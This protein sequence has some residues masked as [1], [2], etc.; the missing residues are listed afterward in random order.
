MSNRTP[1]FWDIAKDKYQDSQERQKNL[2]VTLKRMVSN[3]R[4]VCNTSEY[5]K[6]T[7]PMGYLFEHIK[8]SLTNLIALFT[9]PDT[10]KELEKH[11][12]FDLEWNKTLFNSII[13]LDV[14]DVLYWYFLKV[15]YYHRH[16]L[17]KR[18]EI[19]MDMFD[20]MLENWTVE[21]GFNEKSF[22]FMT[23]TSY[24]LY[25]SAYH[26]RSNKELLSKACKLI[27]KIC[28]PVN[29]TNPKIS[30]IKWKPQD[31]LRIC[32]IS[33]SLTQDTSVLRDRMGIILNLPVAQFDVYYATITNMENNKNAKP[34]SKAFYNKM[35]KFEKENGKNKYIHLNENLTSARRTL[36]NYDFH[37]IIYPDLGMKVFQTFL[38]YSRIAPIQINTW[39]HSDTSGIDTIDYYITSKF[40]EVQDENE[41]RSHYSEEPILLPSFGT[42][43]YSPV[44]MFIKDKFVLQTRK[45]LGFEEDDHIYWCMQTFYKFSEELED[46][47][48]QIIKSDPK[49]HLLLSH[50]I[51]FCHSHLIRMKNKFGEESMKRIHTYP[52]EGKPKF[53]SMISISDVVLDPYPFGGCNSSI[54]AFDLGIPVVSMP[55]KFING[56]FTYGFY[57][58]MGIHECLVDNADDYVKIALKLA[59]NPEYR[60]M[61]VKKINRQKHLLFQD[62]ESVRDWSSCLMKLADKHFL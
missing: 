36:E 59:N 46:M 33:D 30:E 44:D 32:F 61:I 24:P 19:I 14:P 25:A 57:Q 49:A 27:R 37:V 22:L 47:I 62:V 13:D 26:N 42:F 12:Y 55:S 58:K 20:Y 1:Y 35:S 18:R 7:I 31:R 56:R 60:D 38:A 5:N 50:N 17:D 40:F 41:V 16:N 2:K 39:G 51:P 15:P 6:F 8:P 45:D 53:Y 21:K 43:Y 4:R 52:A 9:N 10:K 54:E 11:N 3:L 48:A 34:I 29:Y 23:K 28:P